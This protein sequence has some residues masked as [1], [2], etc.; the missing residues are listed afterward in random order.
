MVIIFQ[1]LIYER[2]GQRV[3][4]IC[5][6]LCCLAF[7][8]IAVMAIL[9]VAK[10]LEWIYF[11]YALSMVKLAITLI[12]YIPQVWLNFRRKSTIGWSIGNVLLDFSGGILSVTQLIFDC[13]R[14]DDWTGIV[15]NVPKF[16][17]GLLSMF[18]DVIF[19]VQHYILYRHAV[20]PQK[21]LPEQSSSESFEAAKY[22]SLGSQHFDANVKL[23]N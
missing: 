11:L 1:I 19:M 10:V 14:T 7:L 20:D 4:K 16:L 18:F 17:L 6:A 8:G 12:K 13:W 21:S 23:E 5:I 2:G 9:S 3:S 15:G 22:H